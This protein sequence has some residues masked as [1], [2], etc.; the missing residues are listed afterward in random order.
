MNRLPAIYLA[1][2]LLL[3]FL[4][5]SFIEVEIDRYVS[6]KLTSTHP[7]S[8]NG[9]GKE[10]DHFLSVNQH[11]IREKEKVTFQLKK[12]APLRI[13][14][15]AIEDD[16]DYPDVGMQ[17]MTFTYSDLIAIDKSTFEI[18][19]NVMENGGHDSGKMAEWM[20]IFELARE[21]SL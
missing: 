9:V 21:K 20:F 18:R 15:H 12:R 1:A 10:W 2:I 16:R 8:N 13:E 17:F 19:V 14:A 4:Q 6:V 7:I 11:I 3:A 5:Y